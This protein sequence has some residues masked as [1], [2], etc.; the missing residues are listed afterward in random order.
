MFNFRGLDIPSPKPKQG[1]KL[2]S[3]KGD[4]VFPM[5]EMA[6]PYGLDV[7]PMTCRLR[8]LNETLPSI[9]KMMNSHPDIQIKYQPFSKIYD[10][11]LLFKQKTLVRYVMTFT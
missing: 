8:L 2:S 1:I 9:T 6:F 11:T 7:Y 10:I 5:T 4:K 3:S